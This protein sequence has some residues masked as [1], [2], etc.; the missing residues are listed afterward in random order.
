M[1]ADTNYFSGGDGTI[2]TSFTKKKTS[3]EADNTVNELIMSCRT[4]KESLSKLYVMFKDMVF[5]VAFGITSDYHLAEDCVTETFVRLTQ[6]KRFSA[7]KGDGKGFIIT[8]AR[9]VAF[10]LRRR[11]KK[12][13]TNFIIQSYGEAEK[14]VEDSIYINQLLKYLN[15]KQRETVILKC[16]A[17][18]TFKQIAQVMKCPETTAK[19][20]YKKAISILQEKAGEDQ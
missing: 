13:I 17:E 9:N 1:N 3:P 16:C 20:R 14:T 18:L 12:E 8:I 19:S 7:R 4:S 11:Y 2:L 10:E 6:V 15:D 5:A